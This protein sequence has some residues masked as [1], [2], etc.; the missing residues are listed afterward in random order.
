[1]RERLVRSDLLECVIGLGANL[2][3]NSPMEACIVICRTKK[4]E[5]HKGYVLFINAVREVARKNAESF[6]EPAHIDRI[7][8]AYAEY[9]TDEIAKKVS[10]REIEKNGFSLSLPLYVRDPS[11][12]QT[13]TEAGLLE[14]RYAD[15]HAAAAAM[16]ESYAALNDMIGGV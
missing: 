14:E 11:A 10:V 12:A 4:P 9:R 1:M 7:A 16:W 3:Y 8:R 5:S 13:V 6:L 2:F 15:W